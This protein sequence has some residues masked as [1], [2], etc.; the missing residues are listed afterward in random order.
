M[1]RVSFLLLVVATALIVQCDAVLTGAEETRLSTMASQKAMQSVDAAPGKRSLRG[2][3]EQ[4]DEENDDM[5]AEDEARIVSVDKLK[6]STSYLKHPLL[7]PEAEI[8]AAAKKADELLQNRLAKDKAYVGIMKQI[9]STSGAKRR[10]EDW[11][12]R[13]LKPHEV[14]SLYRQ[15]YPSLNKYGVEWTAQRLYAALYR[16]QAHSLYPTMKLT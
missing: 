3:K 8:V 4:A 13:G 6:A 5:D 14:A 11:I 16:R 9:K 15:V 7:L 10:I 1:T 12:E 2:I